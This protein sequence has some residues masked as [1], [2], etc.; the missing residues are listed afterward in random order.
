MAVQLAGDVS[1]HLRRCAVRRRAGDAPRL[2]SL[3]VRPRS[4]P[5][6][7]SNI[8]ALLKHHH[9]V[10]SPQTS[11]FSLR[12]SFEA[13]QADIYN[14]PQIKDTSL[15]R[16]TSLIAGQW[17]TADKTFSVRGMYSNVHEWVTVLIHRLL[18]P[19]TN[20]VISAVADHGS[21][22]TEQ[23]IQAAHETYK[24]WNARTGKERAVFLTELCRLMTEAM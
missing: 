13:L 20:H 1:E 4:P 16:T 7:Q 24:D 15:W 18:D 9:N 11:R 23:A 19:G 5:S 2:G 21:D 12:R 6:P 22:E 14:L 8:V 17:L 10:G 3:R